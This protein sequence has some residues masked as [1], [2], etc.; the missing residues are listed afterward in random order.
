MDGFDILLVLSPM[1]RS[2]VP[3]YVCSN[4]DEL[5]ESKLPVRRGVPSETL[6]K[7]LE[8]P[9]TRRWAARQLGIVNRL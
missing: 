8:C 4:H 2:T 3:V 6:E 7:E 1:W 9:T 5:N